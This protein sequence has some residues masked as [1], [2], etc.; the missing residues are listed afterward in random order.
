MFTHSLVLEWTVVYRCLTKWASLLMVMAG[1]LGLKILMPELPVQV[2]F[3]NKYN[4]ITIL[5]IICIIF[6]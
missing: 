5:Y 4:N 1:L 3:C 2:T 6:S